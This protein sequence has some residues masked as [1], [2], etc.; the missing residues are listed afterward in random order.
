MS[1]PQDTPRISLPDAVFTRG[2]TDRETSNFNDQR[3]NLA[4]VEVN[5]QLLTV[6]LDVARSMS[7]TLGAISSYGYASWLKKLP[8][9]Y[10]TTL[11]DGTRML[12]V[13][14]SP[15]RDDGLGMRRDHSDA[16]LAEILTGCEADLVVTGHTH[17]PLDRTIEGVRVI[18]LGAV[19]NPHMP[20]MRAWYG[21]LE[22]D[23]SGYRFEP[24]QVEY[25]VS[26][27]I[28][29]I[30]AS[31]H[32]TPEFLLSYFQGKQIS[33]IFLSKNSSSIP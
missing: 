11:P 24:R 33:K 14:S 26:A 5:P 18:N 6:A 20:D 9:E 7:W 17:I 30:Q 23:A 15:G 13:H 3:P 4:E 32:P 29:A 10:H 8:V 31:S 25:D 19:S 12:C 28:D 22:C 21:I 27:V 2:N 16:E 1:A